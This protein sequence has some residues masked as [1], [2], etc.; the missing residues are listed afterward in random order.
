M[1]LHSNSGQKKQNSRYQLIGSK[2]NQMLENM[3]QQRPST[4]QTSSWITMGT[5]SLTLGTDEEW[6]GIS[7]LTNEVAEHQTANDNEMKTVD[8]EL[9][10]MCKGIDKLIV[11]LCTQSSGWDNHNSLQG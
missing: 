1:I 7:R 4:R 3:L 5:E 9:G 2:Q 6:E 11:D 8:R 10:T